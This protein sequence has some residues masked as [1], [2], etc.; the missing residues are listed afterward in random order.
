[1]TFCCFNSVHFW[2]L[3]AI[4][5]QL[6][7]KENSTILISLVS[8]AKYSLWLC[9]SSKLRRWRIIVEYNDRFL[10]LI[11]V[12]S[13]TT[14]TATTQVTAR[15]INNC[16]WNVCSPI[17]ACQT[18]T[19]DLEGHCLSIPLHALIENA[20]PCPNHSLFPMVNN[21]LPPI[22]WTSLWK[23]NSELCYTV[24]TTFPKIL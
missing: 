3:T 7:C 4:D 21:S 10:I 15:L 18:S 24:A 17:P 20:I 12:Y 14:S 22:S 16:L 19:T 9:V 8:A 23:F 5:Y 13:T 1:M 6:C 2:L 11:L